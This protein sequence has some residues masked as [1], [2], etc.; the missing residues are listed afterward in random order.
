MKTPAIMMLGPRSLATGARVAALLGGELHGLVTRFERDQILMPYDDSAA[1][2]QALFTE[3]RPIIAFM[4]SGIVIRHLAPHLIGKHDE[5]P[6]IVVSDD[7]QLVVPL[8]GGHHGANALAVQI[9]E[10][11]GGQAAITTAGDR[12]FGVALDNPPAGYR[13]AGPDHVKAFMAAAL[14]GRAIAVDGSAPWLDGADFNRAEDAALRVTVTHHDIATA[15]DHLVIHPQNLVLGVGCERGCPAD[16][17]IG[18]VEQTLQA[19]QLSKHSVAAIASI[20]VKADE[21][22]V[23]ALAK[24]LS[25]EARFFRAETLE[26]ERD[27][28]QNPS[29]IV[30]KEVGCHGVSEGAALA[31]VG[32]D[33][34]LLVPKVKT[35]KSTL[36]IGQ[37][38]VPLT[39]LKGRKR[40][41]LSIVG[42]GPGSDEWCTPAANRMVREATD[43]VAY[44]LYLDL[45]GK[46]ADGKMRHDFPLGREED[47][48]R[49]AMELAGEGR[50][51]ALICSGDAGIY[52]MATLVYELLDGDSLSDGAQ[53]IALETAPGISALQGA[54][55]RIGAP[56][57]HDFCTISLSDLLTPW[58][59]IQT[60]VKAAAQADFVIA[61]YNPVSLRRRTQLAFARDELLKHRPADCPVI[62]GTNLGREG[63]AIRVVPL[64]ALDINDVDMLTVV[65]VG[66]SQSKTVKTGDGKNWVYTPRGYAAKPG[67]VLG[68]K[69]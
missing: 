51:V 69:E 4:A 10:A 63:E 9:A 43:L 15:A 13:L 67:S 50:D 44:S 38:S 39:A 53:R 59:D 27:R 66:S 49:H 22:A 62:L 19:H 32:G 17:L 56:L 24:H 31:S 45:L 48:V 14:E 18:L 61:F 47:R 25:C 60:R 42:M 20:D 5:P 35:A 12:A 65:L 68:Q 30:F 57:G 40:G 26:A 55:A 46:R 1:H 37:A 64:S 8:L 52:A 11:L 3:G 29:E 36:A 6:V 58:E 28:L 54:A 16:D 21:A 41:R 7:G 33:G 34:T 2:M 23:H